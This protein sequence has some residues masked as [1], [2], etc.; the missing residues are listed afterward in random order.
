MKS[1]TDLKQSHGTANQ[2]YRIEYRFPAP[3][4]IKCLLAEESPDL[5][6]LFS[7]QDA[8]VHRS[9]MNLM[10]VADIFSIYRSPDH[11]KNFY[12]IPDNYSPQI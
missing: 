8:L 4:D 10:T 6:S 2:I 3:F 7:L 12:A 9:E 1:L 5:S 11:F